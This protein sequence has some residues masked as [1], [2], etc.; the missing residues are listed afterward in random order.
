MWFER[1]GGGDAGEQTDGSAGQGPWLVDVVVLP[2]EG[3]N[4]PEGEAISGGLRSLG[5]GGVGQVR[6]GRFFRLILAGDSAEAA[7]AEA[8][9]ICEQLLANPVIHTYHVSVREK[10][11]PSSVEGLGGTA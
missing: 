3:V 4:D 6:A 1:G 2:K 11:P 8:T 9:T 7:T 5:H 10:L